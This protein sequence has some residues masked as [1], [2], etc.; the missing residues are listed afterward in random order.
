M[1]AFQNV[2]R[3]GLLLVV[4]GCLAGCGGGSS[5]SSPGGQADYAE[6]LEVQITSSTGIE[7]IGDSPAM[8]DISRDTDPDPE[9]LFI[10]EPKVGNYFIWFVSA[11]GG[12]VTF[13]V[14]TQSDSMSFIN[15]R[16]PANS[17]MFNAIMEVKY[18]G[19]VIEYGVGAFA[20]PCE[21]IR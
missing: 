14:R 15:C 6:Y 20:S 12:Q 5:P 18:P 8:W 7:E 17:T 9:R 16:V 4:C 2:K 11:N 19:G 10:P 3:F 1:N 21:A 13:T